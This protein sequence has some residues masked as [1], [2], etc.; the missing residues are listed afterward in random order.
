MPD[1]NEKPPSIDSRVIEPTFSDL[2]SEEARRVLHEENRLSWNE[3]TKAHNSHKRDQAKFFREGGNKLFPE[4]T[5]LLGDVT[6]LSVLHLQ[7]NSGQDTLSIKQLGAAKV[8]G[9]DISDEAIDF[10]RQLSADSGVEGTF[11]RADVYDWL[12]EA[13]KGGERWDIVF[14]S[15]GAIIWL[16]DLDAWAKGIFGVLKP[17]GRFVTVEFHPVAWMFD[18]NFD[19]KLPYSTHGRVMTWE[20]GIGDYVG[21]SG[22]DITPSGW[23]DGVQGFRNPHPSHE[24]AWGLSEIITPLINA[25]LVLEHFREYDYT[26][27]FRPFKVMEREDG[28]RWVLP[29]GMPSVPMMYSIGARKPG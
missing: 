27:G 13:A 17:G 7:C 15:Y 25:G 2:T 21:E 12:A 4:E 20:D 23:E 19:H 1:T 28:R 26:G 3:G 16:S 5:A 14:C 9:V 6:G 11:V 29:K 18:E 10:A 8:T 24:F 22:P